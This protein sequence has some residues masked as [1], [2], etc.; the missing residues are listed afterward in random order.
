MVPWSRIRRR[1][2]DAPGP[3]AAYGSPGGVGRDDALRRVEAAVAQARD[4][5]RGAAVVVHGAA[6][7]GRSTVLP[8]GVLAGRP[9]RVSPYEFGALS[10]SVRPSTSPKRVGWPRN[11]PAPL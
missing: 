5:G 2:E 3:R 11:R 4:H 1:R 7:M 6:G 9:H 10:A 8:A